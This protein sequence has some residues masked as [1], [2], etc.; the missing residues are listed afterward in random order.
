[1]PTIPPEVLQF[2]IAGLLFVVWAYTFKQQ[3]SAFV[4]VS[5]NS[6]A[7]ISKAI[8]E[9]G[10]AYQEAIN[11][12]RKQNKELLDLIRDNAKDEQEIKAH[13]I[14][15]LTRMEEKLDKPV[16]CPAVIANRK[17]ESDGQ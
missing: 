7:G 9:M 14:R 16:R 5:E 2:G 6:N 1:M 10:T 11:D 15:V 13:L 17:G 4:R 12:S 8:N 3:N